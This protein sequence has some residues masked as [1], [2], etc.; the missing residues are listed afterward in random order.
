MLS[1]AEC[2][3]TRRRR[4]LFCLAMI[5][6]CAILVSCRCC[7]CQAVAIPILRPRTGGGAVRVPERVTVIGRRPAPPDVASPASDMDENKRVV[8][9]CPDPL[10]NKKLSL[11]ASVLIPLRDC[12]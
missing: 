9:S 5:M 3:K 7:R 2:V 12:N 8:P 4:P 11:P 1:A 10:H 6:L